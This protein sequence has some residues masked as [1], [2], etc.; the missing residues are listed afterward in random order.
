M[1]TPRIGRPIPGWPDYTID[2]LK[3]VRSYKHPEP[4]ILSRHNDVDGAYEVY[5]TRKKTGKRGGGYD[6]IHVRTGKLLFCVNNGIDPYSIRQGSLYFTSEGTM[7]MGGQNEHLER[8]RHSHHEIV[9][10]EW[11]DT[12]ANR[13]YE[14]CIKFLNLQR[15]AQLTNNTQPLMLA[16]SKERDHI[17]RLI[18]ARKKMT[19]RFPEVMQDK[20]SESIINHLER[21]IKKR[22]IFPDLIKAI[23]G[24]AMWRYKAHFKRKETHKPDWFWQKAQ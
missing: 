23:S 17:Y 12:V 9:Y 22:Q 5:L 16:L 1:N 24:E 4:R 7:L 14:N 10:A 20:I 3:V 19:I 15:D 21:V 11:D 2:D 13:V 6:G 8:I 18:V